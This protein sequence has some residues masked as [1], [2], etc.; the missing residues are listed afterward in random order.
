MG[1]CGDAS[2]MVIRSILAANQVTVSAGGRTNG[3]DDA[4][5]FWDAAMKNAQLSLRVVKISVPETANIQSSR[6]AVEIDIQPC[7]E[8]QQKAQ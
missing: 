5:V 7:G 6:I 2:L 8:L 4:A 1:S 3:G